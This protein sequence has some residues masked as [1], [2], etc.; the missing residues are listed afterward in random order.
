MTFLPVVERELR[1]ASRRRATYWWRTAA[2]VLAIVFGTSFY[3]M[4]QWSA[5]AQNSVARPLF[6]LLTGCAVFYGLL[7]GAA[8]TTDCLSSEKREGTLGLLFLTDL[9]G[10]D[11]VLGKLAACSLNAF[12]AIMAV[13]PVLAVPLLIGGIAYG[14]AARMAL[15][16]FNGLFFSLALGMAVSAVSHSA[17]AASIKAYLLLVLVTAGAP[18]LGAWLA[19]YTGDPSFKALLLPSTG[20]SY[21]MALELNF[22]TSPDAFW[23][24]AVIINALSW[25]MLVFASVVTPRSWQDRP[26]GAQR[27]RWRERWRLWSYGDLAE[28]H[29]FRTRLLEINAYFWLAARSRLKPAYV[30]GVFGLIACGWAWGFAKYRHDWFNEATFILTGLLLNT[31]IKTWLGSEVGRQLA[32]DRNQGTL[33]LLL[34]TPLRVRDILHGQMLALMRQFFGPLLVVLASNIFFL[35]ANSNRLAGPEMAEES[36]FWTCLW[37]AAIVMLI[38]DLVAL[39]WVGQW[40]ALISKNPMRTALRTQARVLLLPWA[41]WAMSMLIVVPLS[42]NTVNGPGWQAPLGLWVGFGLGADMLFGLYARE[43]L[44]SEFR[45]AASQSYARRVGRKK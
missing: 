40:Q 24:S 29:S 25:G 11:V 12:Y 18:A 42:A 35:A 32:E 43:K 4:L 44:L 5:Q 37:I 17:R 6:G 38:A 15:V 23:E 21:A 34:S 33:E 10:Y 28:R 22:R 36:S 16:A 3:L 13:L 8:N 14:E 31:L 26:E 1:V 27:L 30:W 9:K 7:S 2:A 45:L 39:Y 20:Y 19:D 41:A